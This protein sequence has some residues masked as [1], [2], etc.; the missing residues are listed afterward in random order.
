MKQALYAVIGLAVLLA[1]PAAAQETGLTDA[2]MAARFR[3]QMQA[4]EPTAESA[5]G[6]SRGLVLAPGDAQPAADA[7]AVTIAPAPESAGAASSAT[8]T[9]T[10]AEN[11]PYWQMPKDVQVNV[12]V[13]FAFDSSTIA[14]AEKP[15][16]RQICGV[17]DSA[18][19]GVLRIVGHTDSSGPSSYNLTLST[20]RAEEVKRFFETDC[21]IAADRLQAVGV[22]EQFLFDNG[23]PAAGV[24][25]RVEFQA[26]S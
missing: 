7:T 15:K 1:A 4:I 5:L 26:M 9:A 13:S 25:R 21:G 18:D 22:G 16:L 20:L 23:D 19:V 2:E 24:N 6:R 3:A 11:T 17:L 12:Q 14:E 8:A 10:V